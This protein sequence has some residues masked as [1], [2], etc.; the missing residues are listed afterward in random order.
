VAQQPVD[1]H[2][3]LGQF[4]AVRHEVNLQTRAVRAQQEQNAEALRVLAGAV[5]SLQRSQ[6]SA[7]QSQQQ[8]AEEQVR[9]L[10]KALIDL[11]DAL[12]LASREAQR[13]QE[14]L[15]PTLGDLVGEPAPW[16]L[17]LSDVE[18]PALDGGP[19]PLLARLLGVRGVEQGRLDDWRQRARAA[20]EKAAAAQQQEYQA[21]QQERYRQAKQG[22]E[23]VQQLLASLV[24]GYRM[25]LQRIE[26]ALQQNGLEAI[27]VVGR[28]FDPERM[29]VLEAVDNSGRPAGEVL[30]EVRRGYFWRDR[31]FRYAQVRVA[32]S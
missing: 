25:G 30:E 8:A 7:S 12:A 3:L 31:I 24:A 28:P 16:S 32:R 18:T 9:P 19:R 15:L 22:M 29:E 20:L 4:I 21:T 13:V 27:P 23:R 6:E 11:H 10:L 26:R 1:L 2:T 5:E 14:D 17:T